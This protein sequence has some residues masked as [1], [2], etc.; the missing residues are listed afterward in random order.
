MTAATH[1]A[2]SM[3]KQF[4]ATSGAGKEKTT[5][6]AGGTSQS[7]VVTQDVPTTMC[8]VNVEGGKTPVEAA[9]T[10][11]KPNPACTQ[12]VNQAV[13]DSPNQI[14]SIE[15]KCTTAYNL[16]RASLDVPDGGVIDN[17]D[18][19]VDPI[20]VERERD[21]DRAKLEN[22][23]SAVAHG[24]RKNKPNEWVNA[25]LYQLSSL[26]G[27]NQ[28]LRSVDMPAFHRVTL[29]GISSEVSNSLETDFC[30]GQNH[31]KN[32]GNITP[33]PA[34]ETPI[35]HVNGE[36]EFEKTI[37]GRKMF[38]CKHCNRWS[39]THSTGSHT[40]NN[41]G[42]TAH[43]NSVLVPDPSLWFCPATVNDA[44]LPE[45]KKHIGFKTIPSLIHAAASD[46]FDAICV[47][48]E[49]PELTHSSRRTSQTRTHV[50][51]YSNQPCHV[52]HY[53]NRRCS[54]SFLG[55]GLP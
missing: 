44:I 42:S 5:P 32:F 9:F 8:G 34:S 55:F 10:G 28:R 37:Q 4:A 47:Y 16:R 53:P 51:H 23:L 13:L 7:L 52:Y 40:G 24:Q 18:A 36:P 14:R 33:P 25:V 15:S 6:S 38:W 17:D 27:L 35:R 29:A 31:T 39:T 46:A 19:V 43:A 26:I 1:G 2:G 11:G 22:V 48:D 49:D 12:L 50:Y 3:I 45:D 20:R 30:Q 54:N 21:R 41:S